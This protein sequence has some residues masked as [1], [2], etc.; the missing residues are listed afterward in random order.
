MIR[1]TTITY[2]GQ[3][4][5]KEYVHTK[6]GTVSK[7]DGNGSEG[8]FEVSQVENLSGLAAKLES[9]SLSDIMVSGLP[10]YDNAVR[11][12]VHSGIPKNGW[13]LDRFHDI[14]RTK[15]YLVD[16]A[17]RQV[18]TVDSDFDSAPEWTQYIQTPSD[19]YN[20]LISIV[21]EL[22]GVGVL[23]RA[24]GSNGIMNA[25]GTPYKT[26]R[27]FHMHF[28]CD[29]LKRVEILERLY[30]LFA[31]RG[32]A[33]I[34][35]GQSGALL[36]RSPVDLAL[37]AAN[38]PV[39]AA[40]PRVVAPVG[41]TRPAPI[42]AAG[43]PLCL[44]ALPTVD[45]N[46]VDDV[47]EELKT[48]PELLARQAAIKEDYI[49]DKAAGSLAATLNPA[50]EQIAAAIAEQR[51]QSKEREAAMSGGVLGPDFVIHTIKFGPL[52]VRQILA[53]CDMYHEALA[54][55]PLEPD[56][57]GGAQTAKLYTKRRRPVISSQAHGQTSVYGL[58]AFA[59]IDIDMDAVL[60]KHTTS[61]PDFRLTLQPTVSLDEGGRA[62]L[63]IA[64][65]FMREGGTVGVRATPGSG[66]TY[67]TMKA[68][69]EHDEGYS[70]YLGP[71]IQVCKQS[72]KTYMGLGGTDAMVFLGRGQ[73][74]PN[75]LATQMCTRPEHVT[76]S[77]AFGTDGKSLCHGCPLRS[78]GECG[79]DRQL[80]A[81]AD[82][83]PRVILA[84]HAFAYYPIPNWEPTRVVIDETMS[85]PV[86]ME[87]RIP[88]LE[89]CQL[90]HNAQQVD[91]AIEKHALIMFDRT[92][93]NIVTAHRHKEMVLRCIRDT[94]EKIIW[95]GVNATL[96]ERREY[97]HAGLPTMVLN[98]TLDRY[99]ATWF[100]GAFTS[101]HEVNVQ[102]HTHVTQV[103]GNLFSDAG[104]KVSK[105][106][107]KNTQR[108]EGTYQYFKRYMKEN[109]P[110]LTVITKTA[111]ETL[112][113][114]ENDKVIHIGGAVGSNQY[115]SA[116][117]VFAFCHAQPNVM[118][119][120][121]IAEVMTGKKIDPSTIE[122]QEYIMR[123]DG[124]HYPATLTY[125]HANALVMALI[126]QQREDQIVQALDRARPVR[127][128][129]NHPVHYV[130]YCPI[131]TEFPVDEVVRFEDLTLTMYD[132]TMMQMLTTGDCIL[133]SSATQAFDRRPDVMTSRTA[134]RRHYKNWGDLADKGLK[135]VVIQERKGNKK[136][137]L[138]YVLPNF[139]GGAAK[140][141]GHKLH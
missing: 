79:Y 49:L 112:E 54:K 122:M 104:L 17:G 72:Y 103:V 46:A 89:V 43:G 71:S 100:V 56:Y 12:Y 78:K 118:A 76:K 24:S 11:G 123:K 39:F 1:F 141:R 67:A 68:L 10:K 65:R 34:M 127:A 136:Q 4:M 13:E 81:V 33:W 125:G 129:P 3:K 31:L 18:G 74:D 75:N 119:L 86:D 133:P 21:P 73:P 69:A 124:T 64:E 131:P 66:K 77:Q 114:T 63:G 16:K 30:G 48:R 35:I 7:T 37:R 128:D 80:Q 40:K 15:E 36:N 83:R 28:E 51:A 102:R 121:K 95:D 52:T 108:T 126:R 5:G 132:I 91:A 85:S 84:S 27:N 44:S 26:T 2:E 109:D 53:S 14:Q 9:Y 82:E 19:Y 106:S 20:F 107:G 115:E 42:L 96:P 116:Q 130:L 32:Y 41:S 23:V 97:W 60:S 50:P 99:L 101:Y 38:Q 137:V 25:D 98:G 29:G 8:W 59:P 94:P 58:Q 57:R 62:V 134:A 138:G 93:F 47:F 6:G 110:D 111:R 87:V 70:L 113:L 22:V 117:R 120:V 90:R 139:N 92:D 135:T 61:A 45:Q 140:L 55:D 88:V 105:G